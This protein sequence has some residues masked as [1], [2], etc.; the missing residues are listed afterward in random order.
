MARPGL[1]IRHEKYVDQSEGRPDDTI[2]TDR[3]ALIIEPNQGLKFPGVEY[4]KDKVMK[5]G[6]YEEPAKA[7]ILNAKHFSGTDY[8][9][10]Q[11]LA[12]ICEYFNKHKLSFVIACPNVSLQIYPVLSILLKIHGSVC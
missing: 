5:H 3:E 9:T 10:V 11:G 12:Q 4:I 7:I 2:S 1:T 8:S 6:V